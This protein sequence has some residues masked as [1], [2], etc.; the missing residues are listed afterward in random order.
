MALTIIRKTSLTPEMAAALKVSYMTIQYD[1]PRTCNQEFT[2]HEH[3]LLLMSESE[4]LAQRL[5]KTEALQHAYDRWQYGHTAE[6]PLVPYMHDPK[7]SVTA[8]KLY[9]EAYMNLY[10]IAAHNRCVSRGDTLT[11]HLTHNPEQP[12]YLTN[13]HRRQH[14]APVLYR[15]PPIKNIFVYTES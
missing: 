10:Y 4:S 12:N 5:R 3:W 8:T 13:L 11:L 15:L 1:D 2:M 7:T 6:T 9:P 14:R